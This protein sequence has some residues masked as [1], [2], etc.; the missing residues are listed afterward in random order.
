MFR[1][2]KCY[3]GFHNYDGPNTSEQ[4][5]VNSFYYCEG[6]CGSHIRW[7]EGLPRYGI[8]MSF[9]KPYS[10]MVEVE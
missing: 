2:L 6:N 1:R 9:G 7:E 4:A 3:F 10:Y 8:H 5:K